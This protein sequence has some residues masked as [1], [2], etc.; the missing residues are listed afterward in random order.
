MTNVYHYGG[1]NLFF[2]NSEEYERVKESGLEFSALFCAKYPYH[3]EIV[4][5]GKSCTQDNP[6]YL[7]AHRQ[8]RHVMALNMVDAN[9][10]EFFSDEM[11]L[12]GIGFIQVELMYGRDVL[13]VCNHGES[14]SPTMCL[15]F[16]ML[17]GDFD[18]N[19]THYEVFDQYKKIAPNWK[20]NSGILEYCIGFWDKVRK[21]EL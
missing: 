10:P 14:R 5:Y 17:H 13:V 18:Y 19:M 9:K 2:C 16:L 15:M 4:G 21:G 7:V 1:Y 11:I 3:K 12:K 8:D 20:P 6:E